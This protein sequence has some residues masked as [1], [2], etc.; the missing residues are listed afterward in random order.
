MRINRKF[1]HESYIYGKK[2][3]AVFLG[4][5]FPG[6]FEK[7]LQ[8]PVFLI[9]C[10]RSGTTMLERLLRNHQDICSFSEANNVWDP[11]G[12][13]WY[14]KNLKRPPIWYNP[15]EYTKVWRDYFNMDYI[16]QIRNV[17]GCYQFLSRKKIFLNKSPMNTFRIPDILAIFPDARFIH[18]IR[19]GRAVAFS[20]AVKEYSTMQQHLNVYKKRGYN[21]SFNELIKFTA[22]SWVRNIEEVR[23]Q[24]EKTQL[25]HKNNF[26]EFSYEEFCI[27]P[28]KYVKLI[29][30]FLS[31]DR[32]RLGKKDLSYI[33]SM[34]YKWKKNL[35]EDIIEEINDIIN[36]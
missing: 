22:K 12:Y 4:K 24:R 15:M 28:E 20:W 18:I 17:F 36:P 11:K 9:G 14:N 30:Q 6:K 21:Y 25:V 29:C 2:K 3:I 26:I 19:D 34:N 5:M 33:K 10:G 16:R 7:N 35:D 32:D 13:R 1:I 23:S 27:D 8:N 31:I